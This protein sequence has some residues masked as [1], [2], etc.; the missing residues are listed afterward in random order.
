MPTVLL[1]DDNKMLS[2]VEARY[3]QRAVANVDILVSCA[4]RCSLEMEGTKIPDVTILDTELVD[5]DPLDVY[6]TLCTFVSPRTIVVTGSQASEP[7]ASLKKQQEIHDFLIRPF[8]IDTL[9]ESVKEILIAAGYPVVPYKS[10]IPPPS[11][12]AVERFD[13]HLA[14]NQLSGILGAVRALEA[15]LT[16]EPPTKESIKQLLDEYIPRIVTLV[17]DVSKNIKLTKNSEHSS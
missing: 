15:E 13:R 17:N 5:R 10:S 16:A 11:T 2:L 14:L 6:R 9:I 7:F 8:S 12:E 3:I 1:I 4:G